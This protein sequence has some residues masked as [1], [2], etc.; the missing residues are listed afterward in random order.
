[1]GLLQRIRGGRQNTELKTLQS[2]LAL[3]R[4][5]GVDARLL[6]APGDWDSLS[7]RGVPCAGVL[8]AE[9]RR[10]GNGDLDWPVPLRFSPGSEFAHVS[11]WQPLAERIVT[12]LDPA[13]FEA[14]WPGGHSD[15][16][17]LR[18]GPREA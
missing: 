7:R 5:S 8:Q 14:Y 9:L 4:D 12:R 15:V 3:L 6:Q 17:E 13:G 11:E 1:M 16:I 10:D 18:R 2:A